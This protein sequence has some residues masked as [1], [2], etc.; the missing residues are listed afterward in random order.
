MTILYPAFARNYIFFTD[1]FSTT[2]M[3]DYIANSWGKDH[4]FGCISSVGQS[5]GPMSPRSP[6]RAWHATDLFFVQVKVDEHTP[7]MVEGPKS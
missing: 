4:A 7:S 5:L 3:H 6:V 1:V 2:G